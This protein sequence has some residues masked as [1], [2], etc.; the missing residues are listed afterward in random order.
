[1]PDISPDR[2]ALARLRARVA[3]SE[4]A[5][6]EARA[7]AQLARDAQAAFARVAKPND[8]GDAARLREL[9]TVAQDAERASISAK[10]ED[11][12]TRGDLFGQLGAFADRHDP[13]TLM[14][15]MDDSTP[16]LLF[17][18]RVETRFKQNGRSSELWVRV[19]PD[20][21]L[22]ESFDELL[23]TSELFEA[24][25]FWMR[26]W[27]AGGADADQR[28]A[29]RSLVAATGSSRATWVVRALRPLNEPD[30]PTK[31]DPRETIVVVPINPLPPAA[32]KTA[33]TQYW[34]A[35]WRDPAGANPAA[36]AALEAA[37]GAARAAELIA[38]APFNL[39]DDPA[40]PLTRDSAP[41]RVVF[42]SLPDDTL[43][44]TRTWSGAPV[45]RALP[46]RFVLRAERA[47]DT[48][49]EVV[50]KAIPSPLVVGPDPEA[51]AADQLSQTDGV[52]RVPAAI[53]WMVD[54]DEA[55]SIGM[56][57]RVP[58]T[59]QQAA[60]GFD[61]LLV[62]GVRQTSDAGEGA[63]TLATLIAHHRFGAT[64]FALVPQGTPTNNTETAASGFDRHDDPDA[65][66]DATFAPVQPPTAVWEDKRDGQWLSELLGI[67]QSAIDGVEHA[68][69]RDQI[70]GRAMG[71]ALWPATLGYMLETLMHPI[72]SGDTVDGLRWFH[73][74]FVSGR[75]WV[76]AVRIGKQP[77]GILP[78]SAMRRW[79]WVTDQL[80]VPAAGAGAPSPAGR[81]LVPLL[82]TLRQ[83]ETDWEVMS[84]RVSAVNRPGD[85]HQLLLDILGLHPTS[86]E[87]YQ[88]YAQSLDSI[89]ARVRLLGA[90]RNVPPVLDTAE[91]QNDARAL[92]RQLGYAGPTDPDILS[93]IFYGAQQRLQGPLI[94][95]RLLSERDPV[96][97]Y[98][99]DGR[100]YLRWLIDTARVSLD[101]LRA[102]HGFTANE[103][104]TALLYLMLRHAL[105]LGYWDTS[106]RL[107]ID[108]GVLDATAQASV[109]RE[110]PFVH[111]AAQQAASES[112]WAM[113]YSDDVRVTGAPGRLVADHIASILGTQTTRHLDEQLA[114]LER[115][116]DVPTA[117]LE[118]AF[119]EHVDCASYRLDAWVQ[120]MIHAQ[121]S[122]MRQ[123]ARGPDGQAQAKPGIHLGAFGWLEDVRPHARQRADVR[124]P[125]DLVDFFAPPGSVPLVS[126]ATNGGYMMTPSLN[127][128]VTAAVLR[129]GYLANSSAANPD[130][131][132]VNLSSARV[133]VARQILEG[134]RNGQ[135]L[136]ALLGYRLERGLH[137][138]HA[139][140]EV[141]R[142]ILALR[143]Q[144]PLRADRLDDT[145]TPP[146]VSIETIEA[147]N[148]VDGALL[149]DRVRSTGNASYPF[150]LDLPAA[151]PGQ[152]AAINAEVDALLDAND[153]VAD[154]ALAEGV[155]QAAQGNF[156]RAAA[157]L[158]AYGKGGLP[159]EPDVI[160]TPLSGTIIT[161]RV[162][163][164]LAADASATVS[165]AVGVAMTPRG[166]CEPGVNAWLAA[167]AAIARSR[168]LPG[169]RDE[170]RHRSPGGAA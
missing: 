13:R 147:R 50:G 49:L 76:P 156:D 54:F 4:R 58:L 166:V 115:L 25:Q 90:V 26:W 121:L 24:R 157:N 167:T 1:M 70:V 22:V 101:A 17:P 59:P 96:R 128:A 116:K 165:P 45:V 107:F 30:T 52:L 142:F 130:S 168:L 134:I 65:S 2:E 92:L 117:Q 139:M 136:G 21:C 158:D 159:P 34:T 74:H 66:Y 169:A 46:E 129:S 93:R 98:T 63:G 145:R 155:H 67:P 95:D 28:A 124:L 105:I 9:E 6:A 82:R 126:D 152:L 146:G 100:N 153:A 73:N 7:R 91:W 141:D 85:P 131:F 135:S 40:A 60:N 55:V 57:F 110:A 3:D 29:W 97:A 33:A 138:R 15:E 5:L 151:S 72:F 125:P 39:G 83:L 47:G 27:R 114:A 51:D 86:V 62:I 68:A 132:S 12:R 122:V 103:P 127:H 38:A 32:E 43:T 14:A 161:H 164:H 19:Y 10:A 144:F 64:G 18:M 106:V 16:L 160:R 41:V 170:R 94:D 75:G 53:R 118:R 163:L 88:R 8:R 109:R 150:G 78:T 61:R 79:R 104:P 102:E 84:Q 108:V 37:V 89:R 99:D 56:G 11:A 35:L 87:Y 42:I 48:P 133:R 154:L 123:S 71:T 111:V 44:T 149:V 20:A 162:A 137:D 77:Y 140:A 148:V 119:A 23:S 113:L 31:A 143:K 69:G 120:G 36:R 81:L 80:A 112:R